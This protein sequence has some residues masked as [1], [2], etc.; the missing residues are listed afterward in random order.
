MNIK[1]Y[2]NPSELIKGLYSSYS[3]KTSNNAAAQSN[4]QFISLLWRNVF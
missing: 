1:L 4:V 2:L 3:I